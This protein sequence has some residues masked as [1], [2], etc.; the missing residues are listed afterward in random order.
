[1]TRIFKHVSDEEV[2]LLKTCENTRDYGRAISKLPA[3]KDYDF[4]QLG[5][6]V[7]NNWNRREALIANLD[8]KRR[9]IEV[10]RLVIRVPDTTG[11][12]LPR[13]NSFPDSD[14]TLIKILNEMRLQ[15]QLMREQAS[16]Q[17][18]WM[19]KAGIKC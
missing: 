5:Q 1:M 15:T 10:P 16:M 2:E 3:F 6:R 8:K 17:K 13:A 19:E 18:K 9:M 7:K 11:K 4:Y 12:T 14:E